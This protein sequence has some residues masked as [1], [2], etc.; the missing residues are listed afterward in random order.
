MFICLLFQIHIAGRPPDNEKSPIESSFHG[1]LARVELNKV[2]I[3]AKVPMEIL[4]DCQV[5]FFYH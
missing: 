2:N 1:C 4:Q 3:L 5:L